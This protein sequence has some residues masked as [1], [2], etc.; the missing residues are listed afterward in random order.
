MRVALASLVEKVNQA[1][2]LSVDVRLEIAVIDRRPDIPIRDVE[3]VVDGGKP[4]AALEDLRLVGARA[5]DGTKRERVVRLGTRDQGTH[6]GTA[7]DGAG[8]SAIL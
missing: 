8:A 6:Y 3:S 4:E 1:T 5:L 7:K 2:R